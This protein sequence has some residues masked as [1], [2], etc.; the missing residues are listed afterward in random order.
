MWAITWQSKVTVQKSPP[1]L[2]LHPLRVDVNYSF[3]R[4]FVKVTGVGSP[5]IRWIDLSEL[6]WFFPGPGAKGVRNLILKE[7]RLFKEMI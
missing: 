7:G 3:Q 6:C 1:L 4:Q 5:E 2:L